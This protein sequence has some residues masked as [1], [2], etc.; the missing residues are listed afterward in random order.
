LDY[1]NDTIP[2]IQLPVYRRKLGG[3]TYIVAGVTSLAFL[4][5]FYR[6]FRKCRRGRKA[7]RFDHLLKA[8][9]AICPYF[10]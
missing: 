2:K 10:V 1:W 5:G 3:A 7:N 8:V 9:V 6:R 4:Y